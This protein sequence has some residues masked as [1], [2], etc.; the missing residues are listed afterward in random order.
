[1]KSPT[2][3]LLFLLFVTIL[4]QNCGVEETDWDYQNGNN[5]KLVVESIL[6]TEQKTQEVRLSL[7]RDDIN[8]TPT[9]VTDAKVSVSN[10]ENELLFI[11]STE[12][13]GLYESPQ[14]QPALPSKKYT[15]I[16]DWNGEIYS[17][18]N[19]M[20][21]VDLIRQV[22]LQLTSGS[23]SIKLANPPG[24]FS[25]DEQ[26]MYEYNID[27]SA[28]SGNDSSRAQQIFYMFETIDASGIFKPNQAEVYFPSGSRIIVKKYGLNDDF[29]AY[30][31]ALVME[32]EWQGG[33]LDEA[34]SSLPT[35]LS[36]GALGYF[37]ACA[38]RIDTV[39]AQ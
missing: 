4:F 28:I 22:R 27:W 5:G 37:G 2:K 1:M 12:D 23:D 39:W 30:L 10:G 16:I 31:R 19:Q 7:S 34:S 14:P 21:S 9:P 6:T 18:Q 20:V 24:V 29:A 36:N 33:L 13:P 32:V 8:G 25:P 26:A 15:L 3:N 11:A 35:N 17:A 38:V